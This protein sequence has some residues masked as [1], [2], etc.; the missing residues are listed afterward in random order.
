MDIGIYDPAPSQDIKRQRNP[1][2]PL[3]KGSPK[4]FAQRKTQSALRLILEISYI[5]RFDLPDMLSWPPGLYLLVK[6]TLIRVSF[7]LR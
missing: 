2:P 3:R 6:A 4:G 7:L 1:A 5:M